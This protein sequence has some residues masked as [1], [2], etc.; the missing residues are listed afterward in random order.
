MR[1][2]D[3]HSNRMY[4]HKTLRKAVHCWHTW[5]WL[6][7][8][9]VR[10]NNHCP[11]SHHRWMCAYVLMANILIVLAA[12]GFRSLSIE[13]NQ[14]CVCVCG[15]SFSYFEW[16]CMWWIVF[17]FRSEPVSTCSGNPASAET[18]AAKQ[19]T[20]SCPRTIVGICN[21][22]HTSHL[23]KIL[24]PS[25]IPFAQWYLH[26]FLDQRKTNLVCILSDC[27]V[28]VQHRNPPLPSL[29]LFAL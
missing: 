28:W 2:W 6:E 16:K 19:S 29:W 14:C 17:T 12:I 24:Q 26:Q 7:C 18:Q 27:A 20:S 4:I 21:K 23:F 10:R 3:D 22:Q 5:I 25:Y 13:M 1:K 15:N 11:W 9:L 8:V